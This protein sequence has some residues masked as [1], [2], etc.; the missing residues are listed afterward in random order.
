MIMYTLYTLAT[1]IPGDFKNSHESLKPPNL[2]F[3][4]CMCSCCCVTTSFVHT[5]VC[6]C[7]CVWVCVWVC[8]CACVVCL[9]VH[10]LCVRVCVCVCVCMCCVCRKWWKCFLTSWGLARNPWKDSVSS[11]LKLPF[12]NLEEFQYFSTYGTFV[13]EYSKT[14]F[15]RNWTKE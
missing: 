12:C 15:Q 6:V 13:L 2:P 9:C 14:W 4:L 3:Q 8:V 7:V 10:V 5:V 11:P 1:S